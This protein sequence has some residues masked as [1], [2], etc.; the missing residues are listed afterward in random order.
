MTFIDQFTPYAFPLLGLV[1]LPEVHIDP[2]D[3]LALGLKVGAPNKVFMKHLAWSGYL[4]RRAAGRFKDIG[5]EI[6][7]D[8][9]RTEFEVFEKTGTHDYFLLLWDINR[10]CD[11]QGILRGV[12]RGSSGGSLAMFCLGITDI[13]PLQYN[14]SFAR[15]LSE[16]RMKP[17][18][19]D[20]VIYVD[21][22][23]A[24][25]VDSDYE[26]VRRPEVLKYIE[27]KYQGRTCKISTRLQLTGKTA[28]K[29]A[30]KAYLE[31][32]ETEAKRVTDLIESQYGAVESLE[33]ALEKRKELREWVDEA[34]RHRTAFDIARA[35]E[36]LNVAKGQHPS[37]VFMSYAPLDGTMPLELSKTK[38]IVTAYDMNVAA[39]LGLKGDYLG[40]RT[41]DIVRETC[42]HAGIKP[43]DINVNHS[44][45]YEYLCKS[46]LYGGLFQI[47]DG[48]S[49]QTVI[50]VKPRD[51][52]DLTACMAL[53]RPGALESIGQYCDYVKD[54][55]VKP[56]HPVF[57]E[58]T[59]KT[60]GILLYQEQLTEV[61]VKLFGMTESAADQDIRYPVG[62]KLK[63]EMAKMESV[64]TDL[65]RARG[66]PE[67]AVKA[68]WRTCDKSADYMFNLSHCVAYATLSAVTTYLKA[69]HPRE[70]TLALLKMSRHEPNSQQVLTAVIS[71]AKQ[72]G[73]AI[74]P[75]DL[76]KSGD[77]FAVESGGVRFGLSHIRGISDA[78]MS[79]L[80]SFRRD[81]TSTLDIFN[82]AQEA[83]ISISVLVG[84]IMCGC[85]SAPNGRA[86][87]ALDAQTYN[88]L[89]PREQLLVRKLAASYSDDLIGMLKDLGAKTDE[90]GK[91]Y[92]KESR[93]A[94]LRRDYQPYEQM[95]RENSRNEELTSYL[96]ERH[97]L[98]FSYTS[99]LKT[100]YSRKVE[101][102]MTIDEIG[103]EIGGV[104]VRFVGFVDEV[105][106]RVALKSGKPY[107]KYTMS[108]ESGSIQ[109]MLHGEDN[110]SAVDQFHSGLPEEGSM[111][112]VSGSKG[113]GQMVFC[114]PSSRRGE[115][116]VA[117][118]NPV[119]LKKGEL[120]LDI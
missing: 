79:K 108:D 117:Q 70:F 67:E 95:Y 26:Y 76:L 84:L 31:Y 16:A 81:F 97:L 41:L 10:W 96:F 24:P 4:T 103:R 36:G 46:D 102:L 14:L 107:V 85:I 11:Q 86:K 17:K 73:V 90:K 65:G 63:A 72:L 43:S 37:G 1:R 118:K 58:V 29:D 40:L 51:F 20:G 111:I 25:D 105:V 119:C 54:G 3:K 68:F 98:G 48:L 88:L 120:T 38:D 39:T 15:F 47:S 59:R 42:K 109:V 12:G 56:I 99:T 5:E 93:L 35:I 71:E 74:L 80:L 110:I 116:F 9:L 69:N 104:K 61:G 13:N 87:L 27:D 78:N 53:P 6:V 7:K 113:D 112:I 49:K 57:E 33:Q 83:K 2:S 19:I 21:G 115:S 18:V 66:I 91:P 34:P 55:I 89:T 8:R 23:T 100:I 32:D 64:L 28:L 106:K 114:A 94:T 77:D 62:K 82:A 30:L 60:A 52:T 75:P 50:R 92:I 101:G 45:I 22:K 44:S